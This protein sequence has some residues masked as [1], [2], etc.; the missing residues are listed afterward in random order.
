M[1]KRGSNQFLLLFLRPSVRLGWTIG[2][3]VALI[4][5]IAFAGAGLTPVLHQ[6]AWEHA[7]A[8]DPLPKPWPWESS[9]P[10]APTEVARLGLSA[11]VNEGTPEVEITPSELR[12]GQNAQP[13]Q[14]GD[15][16][17]GDRITVTG[18]DGS[19]RDYRVTGRKVVD[20]HLAEDDSVAPTGGK[21]S[22]V[23]C[24]PLD[25]VAG[26]LRLII[27][28]TGVDQPKVPRPSAEQKL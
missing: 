3:A 1:T 28:A 17:I 15:V 26:S 24:W 12:H 20:P 25:A 10:V 11:A 22:P 2:G 5:F 7:L 27:Q 16:A 6:S 13:Q 21:V 18:S 8:S 19:S 4:A 23:T 14:L 9:S